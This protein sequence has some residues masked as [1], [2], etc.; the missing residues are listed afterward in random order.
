METNNENMKDNNINKLLNELLDWANSNET[1][2]Q[3][4]ND[5][6]HYLFKITEAKQVREKNI[7]LE[8]NWEKWK[9]EKIAIII[10]GI[11]G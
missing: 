7:E 9:A 10:K 8:A 5:L 2:S 1:S 11:V 4:V 3:S 6:A